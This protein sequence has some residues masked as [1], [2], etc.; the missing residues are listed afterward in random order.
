M[1]KFFATYFILSGIY[2]LYLHKTQDKVG[3]FSCS[4]ITKQ[5]ANHTQILAGI[6]GYDSRIE[7]NEYE[8]SVKFFLN[9]EHISN[10]VEGCSSISV[11]IL[12]LAFIV[13]FSGSFK[14]TFF[15]A[16]FGIFT[17]YLVNL[18]RILLISDLTQKY[19]EYSF[20]LHDLVFPAVIY[21]YVFLLWVVWVRYFSNHNQ[22]KNV[23]NN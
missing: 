13:A 23:K 22:L 3:S 12:F 10:I 6:L 5:V 21:G 9:D 18:L 1:I 15:Y 11:I 14:A 2:S 8:L 17:I 20:T 19:P 16:I 7:Q 4:P